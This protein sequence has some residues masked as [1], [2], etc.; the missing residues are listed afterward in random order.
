MDI[1]DRLEKIGLSPNEV[2]VYLY[3]NEN[4]QS[5][6]GKIAKGT[7]I[8]RSSAYAAINSLVAKGLIAYAMQGEVKVFQP[9]TPKRLIEYIKE[10]EESIKE[11]LPEL[12]KRHQSSKKEGQVRMFKGNK[13]VQAVFKDII[14]SKE[15][16]FVWGDDGNL[17][18][19]MP[20][21]CS[22]FVRDQNENN[23]KTK[24]ITR[25]KDVSYS[26]GTTYHYID[27]N[28]KSNIA[29]NIYGDKIGIIIWDKDPEAIIIE[30][31]IAAKSFKS[32][33]DFMWDK[34]E[35]IKK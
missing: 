22:Q 12:Q 8:Q 32:Y 14:R 30:N 25:K 35:K 27:D 11:I 1:K 19:Q 28:V 33:F 34:T 31:E 9:T 20:I 6:A 3:L 15:D 23:I 26:K 29:V 24:L 7:Y 2:K 16:N 10:Q 5:K 4:G 21:F 17:G 18:K 13:G